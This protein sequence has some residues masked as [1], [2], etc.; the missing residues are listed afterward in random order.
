MKKTFIVL[1]LIVF[2]GFILR[3]PDLIFDSFGEPDNYYHLRMAEQVVTEERVPIFDELSMQGRY[4]S[5]APLFHV[6][7][8]EMHLLSGIEMPLLIH[9]FSIMYGLMGIFVVFVFAR[10][11][12]NEKVGL[13]SAFFLATMLYH[14]IRTSGN[15]RP[16]GLSLLLIPAIIYLI[17]CKKYKIALLLSVAQIL[18]HPLSSMNLILF[19]ILWLVISKVKGIEVSAKK[20]FLIIES[21]VLIF[22]VWLNSLPYKASE[23]VSNV[24]FESSEMTKATLFSQLYLLLFSG[25]FILVALFK[26]KRKNFFLIAWFL[27]ELFYGVFG[28][29]LGIFVAFPAAILAGQGFEIVLEK[30]KPY[31]KIFF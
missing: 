19:L 5:Y 27:F 29:R 21:M 9:V 30:I 13:Y 8:A 1:L 24:S 11:I 17:Y 25:T 23:Y 2:L 3:A 20:V 28:T 31:T 16:D 18:L 12:F 15:V 4:Y 26:S 22:L 14:V 7:F 10:K 6:V